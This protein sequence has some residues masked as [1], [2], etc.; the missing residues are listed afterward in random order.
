MTGYRALLQ[1]QSNKSER[2]AVAIE[3]ALLFVLFFALFYALVSYAIVL[4]LQSAF[5]HAAEEGARAAIA[6]DRLAYTSSASY[7]TDGVDPR[8]R[9]TVGESLDWLPTK[10]KNK[11]LGSNNGAVQVSMA[12]NQLTVRVVYEGYTGDPLIPII[13]LPGI[14]QVP[15]MP[16]DI[17]GTAVI[18]L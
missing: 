11:V 7:F 18:E 2:G 13:T 12:G 9:S 14:G 5:V 15:K 6:V 16:D 1:N 17:V 10:S 4:L 8:A 3:F